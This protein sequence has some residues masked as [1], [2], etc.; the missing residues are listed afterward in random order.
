MLAMEFYEFRCPEQ[1]LESVYK[2]VPN[3]Q[4]NLD[5]SNY[6]TGF[7]YHEELFSWLNDCLD[8]VAKELLSDNLKFEIVNCWMNKAHKLQKTHLHSHPNSILSGIL[9]FSDEE[10]GKTVFRSENPWYKIQSANFL[11]LTSDFS[12]LYFMQEI[13]PERGKLILFPSTV[14]HEVNVHTSPSVRYTLAFNA[15]VTGEFKNPIWKAVT[16]YLNIKTVF[17]RNK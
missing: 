2:E 14:L 8:S 7:Y 15:F 16:D 13:K 12:K 3:I 1:L 5:D 9:Y 11:H 6:S 17:P 10:S 4:F